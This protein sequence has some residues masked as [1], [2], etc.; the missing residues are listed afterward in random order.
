MGVNVE[1]ERFSLG[2][3][4]MAPDPWK[5][6]ADRFP[7]G[8]KLKGQVTSVPDFGVFVRID[9][10]VEGLIHVSQLSTERVDKPSS[11]YK[12]GDEVEAEVVS[13][14]LNDRK[15][16]LSVR[17]LRRSEERQEMESYLKRE[18]EGG[19][20][21]FESLLGDELRLDRDDDSGARPQGPQL[22]AGDERSHGNADNQ[23]FD[24]ARAGDLVRLHIGGVLWDIFLRLSERR[25]FQSFVAIFR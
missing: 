5:V 8:S 1:N 23:A 12:V 19:R 13:I 18:K 10:G 9:E 21:S 17:A 6:V 7:V 24:P 20:F 3:K 22:S 14:D 4:Q 25:R 2:I 16:G 11:L 15:I